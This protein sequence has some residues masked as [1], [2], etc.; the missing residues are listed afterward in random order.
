MM[1]K[2]TSRKWHMYVDFIDL[3][4]VCTKDPYSLA[5]FDR[6]IYRTLGFC[7]LSFMD[8]YSGYNQIKMNLTDPK[9]YRVHDQSQ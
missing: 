2:K 4:Q 1:V 7:L 9:K 6:L 3:N 5:S 8:S